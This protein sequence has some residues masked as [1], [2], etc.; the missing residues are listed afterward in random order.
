MPYYKSK[1]GSYFV[2]VFLSG[3]QVIRRKYLG[4][5]M[6]TKEQAMKCEQALLISKSK[7]VSFDYEM[8]VLFDLFIEHLYKTHKETSG[9]RYS[10]VFNKH[11]KKYFIDKQISDITRP[12]LYFVNDS[13]NNM[14]Y[15][16]ISHVVYIAKLFIKFLQIYGLNISENLFF[17]FK[18]GVTRKRV[19]DF[20]TID[21]FKKFISVVDNNKDRLMF[22]ILFFYGLRCGELRALKVKDFKVDRLCIEREVSN[23]SRNGGTIILDPKTNKSFREFPY[24]KDIK[25]QLDRIVKNFKLQ[26][27]DYVFR[28]C[29][30][31]II[32]ETTIRRKNIYYSNLANLRTIKIHEFRH[33][34]AS[35]LFNKKVPYEDISEWLGHS[36]V[37]VT[38]SIYSHLLPVRKE[39]VKSIIDQ[40][41]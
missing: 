21:E 37:I 14:D 6:L 34:C 19:W 13:I 11:I 35:Y 39:I 30:T 7:K 5:K 16:D 24:V 23:K 10:I 9:K 26:P 2:K 40:E 27:E 1:D 28:C 29:R 17:T 32:G 18:K 3:K 36:S 4:E 33:S 22:N 15:K 38:L 12:Y 8:D 20:Y 25:N 41:D 31:R